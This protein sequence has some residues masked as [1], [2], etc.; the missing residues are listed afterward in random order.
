MGR[1]AL[2]TGTVH[3]RHGVLPV[4]APAVIE[5]CRG[6]SVTSGGSGELATPTGVALVTTLATGRG[7]LPDMIVEK[8]GIG[9]GRRDRP[10]RP[11]VVRVVLGHAAGHDA[12]SPGEQL[13]HL[14]LLE[15]TVDDL[16]PRVWPT[17]VDALLTAGAADVW[18]GS[19]LMKKGRPGHVLSVLAPP[20]AAPALRAVILEQTS[21][22]GVRQS[23]VH[24]QVLDRSWLDVVIGDAT[25]PVKI[26]HRH[27]IVLHA[28]PE[29][30]DV[31]RW[32]ARTGQPVRSALDAAAAAAVIAGVVPDSAVPDDARSER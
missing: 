3:T 13:E 11:N 1:I 20:A 31:V 6:W 24:R 2:G 16:D 22:L 30:D 27:G 14:L 17:V 18:L 8:A 23:P 32:A 12:T 15:T 10:D 7:A 28:T 29:F 5:L 19:V 26:G 21:S 9:A 25:I 4:P